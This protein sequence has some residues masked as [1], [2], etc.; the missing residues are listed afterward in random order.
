VW[1]DACCLQRRRSQ[2]EKESG[3]LSIRDPGA[4]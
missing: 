4:S 1:E 3:L 2:T